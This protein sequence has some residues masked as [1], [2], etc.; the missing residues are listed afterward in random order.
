MNSLVD[1]GAKR[2]VVDL[3]QLHYISSAGIG[4][5]I[6]LVQRVRRSSGDLILVRPSQKI[7]KI[8]DLLGFTAIFKIA[9]SE[10]EALAAL[11]SDNG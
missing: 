10:D 8:L 9:S 3:E 11:R 5:L 7:H 4:A 1:A 2:I 6:G